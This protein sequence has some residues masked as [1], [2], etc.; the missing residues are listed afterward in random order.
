MAAACRTIMLFV[1]SSLFL[2]SY[3]GRSFAE[4]T[5]ASGQSLGQRLLSIENIQDKNL[6]LKEVAI[7]LQNTKNSPLNILSILT[8]QG[9]LYH[10]LGKLDKA[11]E[12]AV[13]EQKTA[14]KF[15]LEQPEADAYKRLGVYA[16]YK[17]KNSLA[18]A[19]FQQALDYYNAIDEPIAQANLYNNI[20]LVY[21]AMGHPK[22]ALK[23]YQHAEPLY[24]K[25]GTK[26]DK[27][28]IQ[29]NIAILHLQLKRFDIA[30]AMFLEVIEIR[31]EINDKRGLAM[32]YGD[33]G[34]AY[35]FSGD[36]PLALHF[37]TKSL[38]A[39]RK[40]KDD[41]N[42]AGVLHNIAEL[43][44]NLNNTKQAIQYAKEAITI[45]KAQ[46]HDNAYVGSLYSLAKAYFQQEKFDLALSYIKQSIELAQAMHYKEQVKYSLAFQALI[47]AAKNETLQAADSHRAFLRV[48]MEVA[49]DELN[50][51]LALFDSEQLKQQVNQLKQQKRLQELETA[52]SDQERNFFIIVVFC[53]LLIAF[54]IARRDIERRST[55]ALESK[56]KQ[57]TNE[58]E[59]LMQELT[60]AN[61]IKSQF[62]AN[63]SHEIRTPLTT[64][65][66]QA[67]AI[68][69]GDIN[70]EY[71]TKE[72]E[73]IYGNSLHLLELTNNI[74][75]LSKIEANKIELEL[76]TQN[77]H[78]ILQELANMFT[79]QATSKGLSFAIVHSL[80]SPFFIEID[81][82]RVKQ[83][84]INLCSNAIKFTPKGHVELKILQSDDQITFK[85][86]DSGIGMSSSQ[87]HHL[88]ESFTQ[89]DSS[90]SR[91][92]G[93]T[94]LGLCLSDQLAKIMGGAIEVES[95]LNQGS[96]FV[97]NLPCAIT[98][99]PSVV[100]STIVANDDEGNTLE[101]LLQGTIL[102]ADDHNDNRRLIARLLASLGLNV[103]T[104][105]NGREAVALFEQHEPKIILMD[106][107][108]PEMDG[109]EAFKVIRQKG[110][111]I[112]VFALTANAM[113]HEIE[114]YLS[115]GFTGHLS[116][117]I[118]RDVFISTV[119]KYYE[120]DCSIN[121]ASDKF[122]KVAVSDLVQ[123]FK[124][125]LVLEQQDLILH[126]NNEDLEKLARLSH[127]IAGAAQMFGF[128][129]LSTYALQLEMV[130]NKKQ[131]H[132]INAH[133]QDL[134]NEIDH[135][136]W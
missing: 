27:V 95:E 87:L 17:G 88:F 91:R 131:T 68:I 134:L 14:N 124:S 100:E 105:C 114:H 44:N 16:Y 23:S 76:Q 117:P 9:R 107:Q 102:L 93:G 4:N 18:L 60:N 111:E 85:I 135:V 104:A 116:K 10:Q 122:D 92:F 64:V 49:N 75:D 11:I 132:I 71:I 129:D 74:L 40:M 58:L 39:H 55:Q 84:L 42:A 121:D 67:E 90:I 46:G 38:E 41:Y 112:P 61:K 35:K 125:N 37:L 133:A 29:F 81:G 34:S 30:I 110:S 136:L 126:I 130:I 59:Y 48:H 115:L 94:G 127:R 69:S 120:G 36:Y 21:G 96:V 5:Q 98:N 128:A 45:S 78:D 119:A 83:I 25:F 3:V 70:E 26:R 24:Q 33:L 65:I 79:L 99:A 19:S 43:N 103:I 80:V 53:V 86:T 1:L 32:A 73:I 7:L 108:M 51:Q 106:I 62:L 57:R 15:N 123:E 8:L 28:D 72:V 22:D 6:A 89:G 54:L 82:F 47:Y 63:M 113:S 97:F 101:G 20:G 56:V 118:E 50:G 66:G 31:E 13:L 2:L 12:S 52:S 109:V 77:L